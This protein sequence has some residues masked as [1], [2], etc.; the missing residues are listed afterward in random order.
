MR[1]GE[2]AIELSREQKEKAAAVIKAYV[3]EQWE[4]EI[5]AL[6]SAFFVDFLC[7]NVGKYFYNKGIAD[8]ASYMEEKVEDLYLLTKNEE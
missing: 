8:C 7:E 1:K 4:T 5:G 6:K 3:E 2:G